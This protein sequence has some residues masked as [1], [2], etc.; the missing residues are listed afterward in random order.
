MLKWVGRLVVCFMLLAAGISAQQTGGTISGTVRDNSGGVIQG[1]AVAAT[2]VAT[3]VTN[4]V[5]T[6]ATGSYSFLSLSVGTY[7]IDARQTGF[8]NFQQTNLVLN[9]NDALRVDIT[10]EVGAVSTTVEVS[11]AAA[12]VETNNATVGQVIESKTI[13]DQPLVNRSYVDLMGLQAGVNVSTGTG[14]VS[15]DLS[16]GNVSVSGGRTDANGFTVNGGNVEEEEGN[17]TSIIPNA[18][19]IAE[20][21]IITNS[22][23]AEYGHFSGGAVSVI[24]KSGSNA[25]HGDAF[26][27]W[28]N[29]NLDAITPFASTKGP[30]NHNQYGGTFGGP[31]KKDK[32]FFFGDWQGND[33]KPPALPQIINVPTAGT[34]AG[35]GVL[36][37]SNELAG[38]LQ[39]R[40]DAAAFGGS[41]NPYNDFYGSVSSNAFA[42]VLARADWVT[43]VNSG[44]PY[45]FDG[46]TSSSRGHRMRF[47]QRHHSDDGVGRTSR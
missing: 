11:A 42:S 1:V 37:T 13:V 15:G 24:T 46:C 9:V 29:Q 47:S 17:G 23:N 12:H 19:S 20:F 30:Y 28:R 43:P 8:N 36:A 45:Y 26:E 22:A 18:D 10:L 38:N 41:N 33:R 2:N 39:D 35:S 34:A 5:S 16:A 31:I 3:G 14:T 27:F 40:T 6:N 7:N 44:E 21:K 32:L 25:F 4:T